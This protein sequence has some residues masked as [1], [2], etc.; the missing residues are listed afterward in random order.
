MNRLHKA[1][2]TKGYL[3]VLLI[4]LLTAF[5]FTFSNIYAED[6]S[7]EDLQRPGVMFL[8]EYHDTHMDSV[9]C[10]DCHHIYEDGENVLDEEELEDGEVEIECA[11]CHDSSASLDFQQAYHRQCIGCHDRMR[12]EKEATGPCLCGECH[13]R[14]KKSE[15]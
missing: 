14:P 8:D 4:V 12:K 3:P 10:L 15:E 7:S 5:F 13:I 2:K 6:D 9:D 11:S 1:M